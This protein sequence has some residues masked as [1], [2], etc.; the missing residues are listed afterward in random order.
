LSQFLTKHLKCIAEIALQAALPARCY[1]C[2]SLYQQ[3]TSCGPQ[4]TTFEQLFDA[5]L[6]P[7]CRSDFRPIE[8]PLCLRCGVPFT[9]GQGPDHLCGSCEKEPPCFH[10]ARSTG[11]Y[12]GALR[13]MIHLLKYRAHAQVAQPLGQLLW[14]T[15]RQYWSPEE[16]DVI[17][18][19]PLH[20]R[21]LRERG[22]NQA[23]L[24]IREWPKL[25]SSQGLKWSRAYLAADLLQRCRQTCPQTG[26]DRLQRISNLA[27]AFGISG[28]GD[29]RGLSVLLID[30]VLTTGATADQCARVLLSAGANAVHV[31][32]LAR[33]V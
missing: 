3:R 19:V 4:E 9:G 1:Q 14:G 11:A 15:F 6:C 29:V 17:V 33:A 32:T 13:S 20:P 24:L 31:L 28:H 30:D 18:P 23:S 8:S 25:A 22:F 27:R 16:I 7:V 12:Q 26:L 5:F 21:R 10:A 2:S